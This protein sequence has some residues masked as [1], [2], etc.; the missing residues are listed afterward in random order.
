MRQNFSSIRYIPFI[1]PSSEL[2]SFNRIIAF[3]ESFIWVFQVM[4]ILQF[5]PTVRSKDNPYDKL[6][7]RITTI[8]FAMISVILTSLIEFILHI[9]LINKLVWNWRNERSEGNT[10][11]N[12]N[13]QWK[14]NYNSSK[15]NVKIIRKRN[16]NYYS[17]IKID[18]SLTGKPITYY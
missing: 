15:W 8:R 13:R 9:I 11:R 12:D 2:S 3:L 16:W 17:S 1:K 10:G 5:L 18:T 14:R 6:V 7:V 4:K